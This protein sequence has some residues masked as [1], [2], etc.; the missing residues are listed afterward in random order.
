MVVY[1]CNPSYW[2]DREEDCSPR[3]AQVNAQE[4]IGKQ[5]KS[6]RAGGK[7]F[8]WHS[9]RLEVQGPKFKSQYLHKNQPVNK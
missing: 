1:N 7:R 8:N 4:L 3:S 5:T 9:T 6:K 2:E